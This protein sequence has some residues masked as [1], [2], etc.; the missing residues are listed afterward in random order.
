MSSFD[1]MNF[2]KNYYSDSYVDTIKGISEKKDQCVSIQD[3]EFIKLINKGAFGKVWLVRRKLTEDFY[4]M[5]ILNLLD[6]VF[7]NFSNYFFLI[8]FKFLSK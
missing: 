8:K 2:Q 1:N 6:H 4:A 7:I 5:K 3:F